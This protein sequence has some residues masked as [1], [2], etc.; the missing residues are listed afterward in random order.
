M[1]TL[2]SLLTFEQLVDKIAEFHDR[3]RVGESRNGWKKLLEVAKGLAGTASRDN[4]PSADS[5]WYLTEVQAQGYQG[6]GGEQSLSIE[7]DPTPGITV[8]HGANGS[9][10]SSIADAIETALQGRVREP[11]L[12]GRGGNV[13]IW[14]R[15]H[16]GRDVQQATVAL[17]LRSGSNSLRLR[18]CIDRSGTTTE[19]SARQSSDGADREI[20]LSAT[21]WLSAVTG[22]RPVFSYAVVEREVQL[23]RNLQQFL[24]RLLA[25][26]SCFDVLDQEIENRSAAAIEA[27]D[28]WDAALRDAQ[29]R[30]SEVDKERAREDR[31]QL[32]PMEWPTADQDPDSWLRRSELTETGIALPEV[33]ATTLDN[34][35]GLAAAVEHELTE[36]RE[37]ETSLHAQLAGPLRDLHAEAEI[38]DDVGDLCPVCATEGVPWLDRL[39]EAVADVIEIQTRQDSCREAIASLRASTVDVLGNVA[40]VLA[41]GEQLEKPGWWQATIAPLLDEAQQAGGRITTG[42]RTAGSAVVAW[43]NSPDCEEAVLAA[44]AESDH[45]RQWRHARREAVDDFVTVWRSTADDASQAAV[46]SSAKTRLATL[47]TSLRSERANVL[48]AQTNLKV[49]ALLADVGITLESITVQG[50]QASLRVIDQQDRDLQLSMLSAGQRNALLL[51]PML[52]VSDGGP[53]RFLVLDDPVHAFD[54]VRV[55]RLAAA[56]SEV[57]KARR[58]LVLTHDERLKEHLLARNANCDVRGVARDPGTGIVTSAVQGEM[59]KVLL[60]DALGVLDT[61]QTQPQGVTLPPYDIVRGLCRQAFDNALRSLV[62][63]AAVRQSRAPDQDLQELDDEDRTRARIRRARQ[64]VASIPA[65]GTALDDAEQ[66]VGAYLDG[67]NRSSHGNPPVGAQDIP[68]LRAEVQTAQQACER[69]TTI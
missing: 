38:L 35:R 40:A 69:I 30:A 10:K 39:G 13:P 27:R 51:A 9:G 54:Q 16:C 8:I 19:W 64:L 44:S 32:L 3:A 11:A 66:L 5:A 21:G 46:W 22:Y 42:L 57:A 36:L 47:R 52:A 24:E 62:L 53:F 23:A 6:I 25:F 61:A 55:D 20:D 34:L 45:L 49:E 15:E 50:R 14:E 68:S 65:A 56:V 28:R 48:G 41:G 37:A 2:L 60:L 17:T 59:W 4:D 29:A 31:T 63:R 33:P 7:L 12:E 58:V 1:G 67:W 18:C 26:G 43:V